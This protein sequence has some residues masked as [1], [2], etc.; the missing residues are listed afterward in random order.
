MIF[1]PDCAKDIMLFLETN[2]KPNQK[3]L[4][5]KVHQQMRKAI[6]SS[7]SY[8]KDEIKYHVNWLANEK[9]LMTEKVNM[10]EN[11]EKIA[12]VYISGITK[13]G[14]DFCDSVRQKSVWEKIRDGFAANPSGWL[15]A[16]FAGLSL[17]K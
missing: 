2:M 11:G 17:P 15:S 9:C 6:G 13:N 4:P 3:M 8:S 1:D 7:Y 14:M 16:L 12:M 5:Y 10:V